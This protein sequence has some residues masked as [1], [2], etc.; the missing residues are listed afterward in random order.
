MP[1]KALFVGTGAAKQSREFVEFY[2]HKAFK[3]LDQVEL[4]SE[5]RAVFKAFGQNLMER[6]F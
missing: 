5:T 3:K 2:T 4:K 1:Q 6:K